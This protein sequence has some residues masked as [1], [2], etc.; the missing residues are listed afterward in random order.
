M[1]R[2]LAFLA[3][4]V[5]IVLFVRSVLLRRPTRFRKN[6]NEFKQQVDLAVSIFLAIV[7][8]V[9]VFALGRVA[10]AWWTAW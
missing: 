10:W 8:V 2:V 7:A 9:V 5:P 6:F 1:L 4:A 3:A